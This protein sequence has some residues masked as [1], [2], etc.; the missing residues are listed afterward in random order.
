MTLSRLRPSLGLSDSHP[1]TS[2]VSGGDAFGPATYPFTPV[3]LGR[4]TGRRGTAF[5]YDRQRLSGA[6]SRRLP[7][8]CL[9]RAAASGLGGS[10]L[11]LRGEASRSISTP[12]SQMPLIGAHDCGAGHF[13]PSS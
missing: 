12:A 7:F 13:R 3:P 10:G 11:R 9:Y 2:L 6:V 1:D 5:G 8:P 4:A